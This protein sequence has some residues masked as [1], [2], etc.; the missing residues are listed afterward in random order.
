VPHLREMRGDRQSSVAR[1][2]DRLQSAAPGNHPGGTLT[3][4]AYRQ[5]TL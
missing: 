2:D 5:M 3:Q 1:D 4:R